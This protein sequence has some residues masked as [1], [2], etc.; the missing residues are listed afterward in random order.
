MPPA[1][2]DG[3][4]PHASRPQYGD[5]TEFLP[6]FRQMAAEARRDPAAVPFTVWGIPEDLD[7]LRHYRDLE[8]ARVVV[9]LESASA[10]EILPVL[11]RWAE[12][13]GRV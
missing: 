6:R 9:S 10:V 4:I 7:R 13:I 5:V 8:I 3:W 11:D 12:L 2:G 1:Y